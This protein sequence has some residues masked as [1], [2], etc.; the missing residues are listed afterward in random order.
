MDE[1]ALFLEE[2]LLPILQRVEQPERLAAVIN[3]AE[4]ELLVWLLQGCQPL[5]LVGLVNACTCADFEA[6]GAVTLLLHELADHRGLVKKKVIPLI[7]QSEPEKMAQLVQ[8][9]KAEQL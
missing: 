7:E 9:V 8:G 6:D 3:Q 5:P 2:S 1:S 4:A